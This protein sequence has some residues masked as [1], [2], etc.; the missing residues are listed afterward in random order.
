MK[1]HFIGD[2]YGQYGKLVDLQNKLGYLSRGG[3]RVQRSNPPIPPFWVGD[4]RAGCAVLEI[5]L[6][7]ACAP[8]SLSIED[9][10][11]I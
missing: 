2:V 11:I 1:L 5:Q 10:N 7:R 3:G 4:A 8:T 9:V 6:Y